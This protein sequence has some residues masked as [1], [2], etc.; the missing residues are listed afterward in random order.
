MNR[1]FRVQYSSALGP[2]EGGLHFVGGMSSDGCKASGF[3]M[4]ER[5]SRYRQ[6]HVPFLLLQV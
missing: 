1:G 3:E 6:R 2:Y 5:T 4:K